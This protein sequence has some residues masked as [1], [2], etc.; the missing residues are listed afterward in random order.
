MAASKPTCLYFLGI[1]LSLTLNFYL[2]TLAYDLGC[3]PLDLEPSRPKS[4]YLLL[5]III[6]SFTN[7][8]GTYAVSP[9]VNK[10]FTNNII[11]KIR[12]LNSFR[13]KPAISKIV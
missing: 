1:K 6:M 10:C 2:G 3:F 5:N 12:Y 9:S 11:K 13:R 4:V 7:V 8:K